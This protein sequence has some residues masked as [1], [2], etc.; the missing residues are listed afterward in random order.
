MKQAIKKVCFGFIML[1]ATTQFLPWLVGGRWAAALIFIGAICWWRGV[2]FAW[3]RTAPLAALSALP[4]PDWLAFWRH[5]AGLGWAAV[6]PGGAAAAATK[7]AIRMINLE[8]PP[9]AGKTFSLSRTQWMRVFGTSMPIKTTDERVPSG[10]LADF[11]DTSKGTSYTFEHYMAAVRL[12]DEKACRDDATV[13]H[14]R[15]RTLIGS[16]AFHLA[17][18]I[19]GTLTSERFDG[20]AALALLARATEPFPSAA[21]PSPP[22]PIGVKSALPASVR[23]PEI[24]VVYYATSFA[25]CLRNVIQRADVDAAMP[26]G[27]LKM[28]TFAYAYL[29]AWMTQN[30][31]G[32]VGYLLADKTH[33]Y[34]GHIDS[35]SQRTAVYEAAL[36]NIDIVLTPEQLT[37]FKH[38]RP[39]PLGNVAELPVRDAALKVTGYRVCVVDTLVREVET[40]S[41]SA[42]K[43]E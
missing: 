10:V 2:S 43:T 23:L 28:V 33:A 6:M 32:H 19:D 37:R 9:G 14:V 7:P 24:V 4:L 27:Y 26:P 8:G 15:D 38:A 17:N 20:L 5:G 25:D 30:I 3:L 13:L 39:G 41:V 31:D 34:A 35:A 18:H 42:S 22:P 29:V 21:P 1:V 11:Y 16:V 40:A 12:A 36:K